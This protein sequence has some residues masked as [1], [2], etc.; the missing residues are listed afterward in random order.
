MPRVVCK[1]KR[2]TSV[3]CKEKECEVWR[4]AAV[5]KAKGFCVEGE[6]LLFGKRKV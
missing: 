3:V 4:K 2:G 6:E 1:C 5:C